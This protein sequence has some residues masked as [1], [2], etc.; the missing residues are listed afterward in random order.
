MGAVGRVSSRAQ[1]KSHSERADMP[2]VCV[3]L[4]T[5]FELS[6]GR[7]MRLHLLLD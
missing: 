1:A 5:G 2:F 4:A 3:R 7:W 6:E